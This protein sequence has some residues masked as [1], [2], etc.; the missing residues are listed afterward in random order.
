[1]TWGISCLSCHMR[2]VLFLLCLSSWAHAHE[3]RV[4]VDGAGCR[5]RQLA[6][7]RAFA[8]MPGVTQVEILPL[9]AAP[10]LNQ[11]YFIIR[12][13]QKIPDTQALTKALGRR[14]KFYHVQ[15]IEPLEPKREQATERIQSGLSVNDR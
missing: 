3:Y 6:I 11:R 4:L 13:S 2:L 15:N 8:A 5:T 10:A 7:Q 12:S 1:M 9:A 14:A